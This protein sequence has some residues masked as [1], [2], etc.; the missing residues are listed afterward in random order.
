MINTFQKWLWVGTSLS[1]ILAAFGLTWYLKYHDIYTLIICFG[2]FFASFFYILFFI[3]ICR[4]RLSAV[5]VELKEIKPNDRIIIGYAVSY[6]LP[7]ASI[8]FEQYNTIIVLAV[9]FLIAIIMIL[10]NNSIPNPLLFLAGYHYYEASAE[11]G[12]SCYTLISKKKL[13]NNKK[14]Q[15]IARL[16]EYLL[17]DLGGIS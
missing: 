10:S 11:N 4:I 5:R 9:S 16:N 12:I 14:I 13:R 8:A 15:K 17:L 1:P 6:I 7:F 3:S 2:I